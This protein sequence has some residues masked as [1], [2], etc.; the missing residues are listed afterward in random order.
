MSYRPKHPLI[1]VVN[2]DGSGYTLQFSTFAEA[3]TAYASI[4]TTGVAYLYPSA[5]KSLA[6]GDGY[7]DIPEYNNGMTYGTGA[8]VSLNGTVYRLINFIGAG[9]YGPITHPAAW[10]TDVVLPRAL[11]AISST[12]LNDGARRGI[13]FTNAENIAFPDPPCPS[14]ETILEQAKTSVVNVSINGTDYQI[15]TKTFNL[16]A[17]GDCTA[18]EDSVVFDYVSDGT[19]VATDGTNN[20]ISNGDGTYRTEPIAPSEPQIIGYQGFEDF[21]T[22]EFFS[23]VYRTRVRPQYDNGTFGEWSEWSYQP[24]GTLYGSDAEYNYYSDGADSYYSELKPVCDAAGTQITGTG[25]DH[26][27]DVGCGSYIIGTYYDNTYADG[28]CG[29]YNESGSN[30]VPEGTSIGTCGTN[31]YISNG[32]GTYYPQS[33]C[34]DADLHA[35]VA[36]WTYDGCYWSYVEPCP[37]SGDVLSTDSGTYYADVGC[38][39]FAVGDW[40]SATYADGNCGSYTQGGNNYVANG[41]LVG[42]CNNYNYYSNGVGGAYQGESTCEDSTLHSNDTTWTYD[43][44]H[45]SQCPDAWTLI[46]ETI[47]PIYVDVGCG[48]F[49]IGYTYEITGHDGNC[50]TYTETGNNYVAFETI[51][52]YCNDMTYYSDGNGGYFS[53]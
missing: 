21:L 8:L 23:A 43:G 33:L 53:S 13:T 37:A 2:A 11:P 51:I 7:A 26:T 9:G 47:T 41:Q 40:S 29:S 30:Y 19:Q 3:K 35:G 38:G 46:N 32:D 25:G 4:Q 16:V 42:T 6:E 20:Y 10:T 27:V 14:A 5:R 1:V 50:G 34:E 48:N 36:G 28:A 15:G 45:W 31:D 17:N 44:C 18:S 52:G 39:N 22:N 24:S 49:E 12:G